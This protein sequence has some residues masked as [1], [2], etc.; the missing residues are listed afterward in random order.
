MLPSVVIDVSLSV[1]LEVSELDWGS[2]LLEL[3]PWGSGEGAA[4]LP[5]DPSAVDV[6][7]S[8]TAL[9]G[10]PMATHESNTHAPSMQP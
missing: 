9:S 6:P 1:A 10:A 5:L 7:G 2:A 3:E 4:L 8:L